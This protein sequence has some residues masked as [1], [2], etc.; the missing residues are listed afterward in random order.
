MFTLNTSFTGLSVTVPKL[1]LAASPLS[2]FQNC[3][4][5]SF[6]FCFLLRNL[7]RSSV[8]FFGFSKQSLHVLS[9][10]TKVVV[11]IFTVG[12]LSEIVFLAAIPS[13]RLSTVLAFF[14]AVASSISIMR[15]LSFV[16]VVF[17]SSATEILLFAMSAASNRSLHFSHSN[18]GGFVDSCQ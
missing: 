4:R 14:I 17:I 13:A 5:V 6:S 10:S 16:P 7:N 11:A 1:H 18:S 3:L 9:K 15:L 12:N 2:S 8:S